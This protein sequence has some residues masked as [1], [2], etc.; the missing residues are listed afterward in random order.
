V[1]LLEQA[2][3]TADCSPDVRVRTL[4]LLSHARLNAGDF[5]LALQNAERA[6]THAADV[7]DPDLTSQ[8]LSLRTTIA[9]MC[10]RGV[11]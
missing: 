4:L 5:A 7:D 3:Q 9:C 8:A 11:D 10:G 6:V 2:L 1:D